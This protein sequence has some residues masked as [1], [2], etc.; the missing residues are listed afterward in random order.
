MVAVGRLLRKVWSVKGRT[1]GRDTARL[2]TKNGVESARHLP[3]YFETKIGYK[4]SRNTAS[5]NIHVRLKLLY[6]DR[7]SPLY[8]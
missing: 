1:V 7:Q 5:E 4:E 6:R 2:G 8:N 3:S